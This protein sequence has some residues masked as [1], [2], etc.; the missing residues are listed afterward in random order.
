MM[1]KTK[2]HKSHVSGRFKCR[3]FGNYKKKIQK[4][5][6]EKWLEEKQTKRRKHGK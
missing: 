2:K 3:P 6:F 4:E 1:N 5:E